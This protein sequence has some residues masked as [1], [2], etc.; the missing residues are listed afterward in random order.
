M[1]NK[2][3]LVIG[4]LFVF[5]LVAMGCDNG[6]TS[7]N[8]DKTTKFEGTWNHEDGIRQWIFTG[9]K[10]LRKTNDQYFLKGLFTYTESELLV[11]VSHRWVSGEWVEYVA[12]IPMNYNFIDNNNFV[13]IDV[14]GNVNDATVGKW[15][16]Q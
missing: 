9:N 14:N 16:K 8:N 13:I 6:T 12:L 11:S 1:N 7:D 2:L 4:V 5:C 3:V 10:F 15:T